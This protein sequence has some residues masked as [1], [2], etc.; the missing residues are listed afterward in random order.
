MIFCIKINIKLSYKLVGWASYAQDTQNNDFSKSLQYLKKEV[1]DE[2]DTVT[3]KRKR[4][5]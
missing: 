1:S 2:F 5:L 4:F 3:D